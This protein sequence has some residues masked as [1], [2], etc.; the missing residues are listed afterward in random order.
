MKQK[1]SF[2]RVKFEPKS[3]PKSVT[4]LNKYP[5]FCLDVL[6]LEL[7][8]KR[9]KTK[10]KKDSESNENFIKLKS[11]ALAF[12]QKQAKSPLFLFITHVVCEYYRTAP[13]VLLFFRYRIWDNLRNFRVKKRTFSKNFNF[14]SHFSLVPHREADADAV[15]CIS[16]LF[17]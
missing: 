16:L 7:R 13:H 1:V 14:S 9:N 3:A 11:S 4:K 8:K 15:R 10:Q 6:R 17:C 12:F 5:P 2:F